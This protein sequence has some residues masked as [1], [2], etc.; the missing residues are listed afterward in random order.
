MAR[1]LDALADRLVAWSPRTFRTSVR[2]GTRH[3]RLRCKK[4]HTRSTIVSPR[5]RTDVMAKKAKAKK[6]KVT[7][8]DLKPKKEPKGGATAKY[9]R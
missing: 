1:I 2:R 9:L 8:R 4:R 6:A 5:E 3:D 7:V